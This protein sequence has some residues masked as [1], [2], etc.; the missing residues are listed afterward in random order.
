[1]S[2]DQDERAKLTADVV[3]L[4]NQNGQWHVLLV[5]RG[6]PPY[7]GMWALPGGHVDVDECVED[8][9]RR[10]LAKEAG[11]I[12]A[13]LALTT[14][15]ALVGVYSDPCRDPRGR[16]V[17]WAYRAVVDGLPEPTAGDDA[18]AA[19]WVPVDQ[20]Y[21]GLAFDHD[22]ILDAALARVA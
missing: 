1:M 10:E 2:I 4:S 11:L 17:T 19:R 3:L 5:Q 13:D 16:Y 14:D 7:R 9:A 22:L 12:V 20:A 6:W 21:E 15:L 18:R 8:A